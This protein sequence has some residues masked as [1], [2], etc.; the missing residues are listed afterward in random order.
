M[1]LSVE[2]RFN[3]LQR[4]RIDDWHRWENELPH[5]EDDAQY[6][7]GVSDIFLHGC[8]CSMLLKYILL[9][10]AVTDV[11]GGGRY[12]DVV[13]SYIAGT[14]CHWRYRARPSTS[15]TNTH[16]GACTRARAYSVC[17]AWQYVCA[18][19]GCCNCLYVSQS[20]TQRT[21]GHRAV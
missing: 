18:R 3:R 16:G 21:R 15:A 4:V 2:K 19:I 8:I 12:A 9:L 5:R 1:N 7:A 10:L 14:S 20:R 11:G 6:L 17:V 13:H